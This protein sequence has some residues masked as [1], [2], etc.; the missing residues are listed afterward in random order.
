M[1]VD[2]YQIII[3][4]TLFIIYGIFLMFDLF[5]RNENYGYLAYV[6]A[7]IPINYLWSMG[8]D[9]VIAAYFILFILWDITLLRDTFGVYFKKNKEINEIFLYLVLGILIQIIIS[10]ILPEGDSALQV[11]TE[12]LWFFWLPNI[13]S[14]VFEGESLILGFKLAASLMVLLIVLPLILDIKDEEIPL[15]MFIIIIAIFIL[16]FLYISYIWLPGPETLG[17]LTFLFSVILFVILLI[18]TRSGKETK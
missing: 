2:V 1:A 16:P 13:H 4:A 15:P 12:Q 10:A 5:G 3:L 9:Y 7:V 6:V 18:I 14:A 8:P 11:N 17:V